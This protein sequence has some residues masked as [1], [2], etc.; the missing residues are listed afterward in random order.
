MKVAL[1]VF[2]N[3]YFYT[4]YKVLERHGKNT[5]IGPEKSME[6]FCTNPVD[7]KCA[8]KSATVVLGM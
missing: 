5:T 8:F 1:T 2:K 4:P 7:L 6:M 3:Q